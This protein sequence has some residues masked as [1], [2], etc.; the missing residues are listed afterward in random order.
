MAAFKRTLKLGH[1]SS[2]IKVLTGNIKNATS[3]FEKHNSVV[4]NTEKVYNRTAKSV[5][6]TSQKRI[7]YVEK[8]L[9]KEELL[10]KTYNMKLELENTQH[11]NRMLREEQKYQHKLAQLREKSKMKMGGGGSGFSLTN[12]FA[13]YY[14]L[15]RLTSA[16]TSV[17]SVADEALS[18]KARLGLYNQSQYNTDELYSSMYNSAQRSRTSLTDTSDLVN[19][20][21][22]SGAMSGEGAAT[23]SI[24]ISEIINKALVAGG[25]TKES[26]QRALLQLAQGLSSGSLQGDELRSIRE[27]TPF[28][29]QMLAEGLNKTAPELGGNLQIGDL[30]ELGAQGELTSER[31]LQAFSAMEDTIEEKFNQMPRTFSQSMIQISNVWNKFLEE[32]SKPGG[33]LAKINQLA[34]KIAD[35]LMS[36]RGQKVLRNL[37]VILTNIADVAVSTLEVLGSGIAWLLEN[38]TLL[39]AAFMSL[40][41]A[42]T[43]SFVSN[44]PNLVETIAAHKEL[45]VA[46]LSVGAACLIAGEAYELMGLSAEESSAATK[47]SFK[48]LPYSVMTVFEWLVKGLLILNAEVFGIFLRITE[49]VGSCLATTAFGVIH[50]LVWIAKGVAGVIDDLFGTNLESKLSGAYEATG[51]M[52]ENSATQTYK[53]VFTP[54]DKLDDSTLTGKYKHAKED[55]IYN[56]WDYW[57]NK[58]DKT[59]TDEYI[60]DIER[61]HKMEDLQNKIDKMTSK[62][63]VYNVGTV[64][65]VN[66]V[67][68]TVD[69]SSEDL[70]LLRD[71]ASRD[72]LLS[73]TSVTPQANITFGD[74]RETADVNKIV[75]VIEDM[76]E[77]AFA[78]SLINVS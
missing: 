43:V 50:G 9:K 74:I 3:A 19:R 2:E 64:D 56:G 72:L 70:K 40:G 17:T 77:N 60:S 13:G 6:S 36:E 31:I 8:L 10:T 25:G 26:N 20:I 46:A 73:M 49:D 24:R 78:T 65:T 27:Q 47:A 18:T 44:L 45:A 58:L 32:L 66:N 29:A 34:S 35:Y 1:L 28:L 67:N 33:A 61:Q 39:E 53:A 22:V 51:K 23:E 63:F 16:L 4:S 48:S 54:Y 12:L 15:T 30:K 37:G 57:Y 55:Y 62:D 76:V 5:Q 41:T 69:I 38:T 21:L 52:L 71:I 75:D 14:L 68:G 42:M 7:S 59:Y 11:Q